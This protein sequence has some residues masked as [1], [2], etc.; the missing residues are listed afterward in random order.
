M[1]TEDIAA[2]AGVAKATIYAYFGD[3][4]T[5]LEA[6][7]HRES[8]LTI[9]DEQFKQSLAMPFEDALK[10]YGM[11]YVSFIHRREILGWDKLIASAALKFPEI[12]ERFFKA[13][14]GRGQEMLISLIK[15]AV[16]RKEVKVC[17]PVMAADDLTGLWLGFTNIEVTLGVK[18]E[19]T[20]DEIEN[21]VDHGIAVFMSFYRY[22]DRYL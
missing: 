11:G 19:L 3:K 7:I 13:G 21:R 4:G 15:Q 18:P 9:S 14:P 1:T 17:E 6:V 8:D 5:L 10:F 12:P 22:S 2:A 20:D 16:L